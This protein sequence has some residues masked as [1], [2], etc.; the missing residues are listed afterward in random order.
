MSGTACDGTPPDVVLLSDALLIV[1]GASRAVLV[2]A[3]P[4][5]DE[6]VALDP[7]TCAVVANGL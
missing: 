5:N 2:A 3:N 1:D 6:T 4:Q 7:V